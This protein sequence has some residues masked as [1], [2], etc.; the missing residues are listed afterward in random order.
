M[1]NRLHPGIV[2][3]NKSVYYESCNVL[4]SATY[5]IIIVK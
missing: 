5:D 2:L 1:L 4:D 3:L